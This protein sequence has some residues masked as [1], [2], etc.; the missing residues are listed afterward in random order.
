MDDL[1]HYD[2]ALGAW[3]RRVPYTW[4]GLQLAVLLSIREELR[5][6]RILLNCRNFLA[7]PAH[8]AAIRRNTARPKRRRT[9]RR[10]RR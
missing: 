9:K 1:M 4:D 10:T 3:N 2:N 5:S 7:V 8:L 6:I